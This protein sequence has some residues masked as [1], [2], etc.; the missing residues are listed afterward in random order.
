V[1]DDDIIRINTP[2]RNIDV[3]LGAAG[4][5]ARRAA[6][7]VKGAT[8]WKPSEVR[9]RKVTASLRAYVMLAISADKGAV[10][11]SGKLE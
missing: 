9:P 11:D 1:Q 2:N 4:L 7:N 5:D 10:R 6:E 3:V 8:V